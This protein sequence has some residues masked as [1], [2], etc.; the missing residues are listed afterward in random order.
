[1]GRDY[2]SPS[3]W[4]ERYAAQDGSSFDW[5]T[6]YAAL[7]PYLLPF[8]STHPAFEI[9]I[10]GCGNSRLGPELHDNGFVNLTCIDTS[11]VVINQMSDRYADKEDMEFTVMDVRNME[12]PDGCFDLI[13]DKALFDAMLCS[14][15]NINNVSKMLAEVDRALKPSGVYV[16]FS[17]GSPATRLAYLESKEVAWHVEVKELAKPP[18]GVEEDSSPTFHYMYCCRKSASVDEAPPLGGAA[19]AAASELF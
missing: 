5:Y 9:L 15:D 8:L 2:G 12:I 10:A 13:L 7:K 14:E 11:T 3:F 1:M 16:V 4:D 17:H 18:T 19:A 6:D